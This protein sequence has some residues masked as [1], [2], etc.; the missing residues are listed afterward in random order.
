MNTI[1]VEVEKKEQAEFDKVFKFQEKIK[2]E[3]NFL[4]TC[5]KKEFQ[6]NFVKAQAKEICNY[7]YRLHF[8]PFKS[9]ESIIKNILEEESTDFLYQNYITKN[10]H[11]QYIPDED[12]L[13][14]L[15]LTEPDPEE[16]PENRV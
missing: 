3:F 12:R 10:E 16:F 2:K 14:Q 7:L 9:W 15:I 5:D 11:G 13:K 6:Y 8:T 1:N 4:T